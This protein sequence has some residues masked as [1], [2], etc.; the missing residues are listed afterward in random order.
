MFL[1]CFGEL[2][3]E[4]RDYLPSAEYSKTIWESRIW[5]L[6]LLGVALWC[7]AVESIMPA[8]FIGLP[9]LYGSIINPFFGLTQHLGLS[10][11][12]LDHRLNTRTIYTNR[13]TRFIYWN[14]NYHI[15]HH[16]YPM[17]PYHALPALHK[18]LKWDMPKATPG[19]PA[20]IKEVVAALVRQGRDPGYTIIRPL[21]GTANPY[22]H[23]PDKRGA[24]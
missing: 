18:E 6:I 11:D 22:R 17:V 14:M 12:V 16:M 21:P 2:N 3:A 8:M 19:F 9:T 20:A 7:I 5:M 24:A 15:E 4:E 10:E 1:H 23:D 13:I